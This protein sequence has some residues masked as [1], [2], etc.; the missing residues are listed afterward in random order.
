MHG[1]LHHDDRY[2]YAVDRRQRQAD[3][4]AQ[5]RSFTR[6]A[7]TT[8]EQTIEPSTEARLVA[9]LS[10]MVALAVLLVLVVL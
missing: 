8:Q 4:W 2:R 5:E 6:R 3:Q 1:M 10:P 7:R 9:V